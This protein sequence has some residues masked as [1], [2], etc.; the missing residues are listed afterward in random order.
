MVPLC[1]VLVCLFMCAC[2]KKNCASI[3][4]QTLETLQSDSRL[5]KYLCSLC[6]TRID[7][8][9]LVPLAIYSWIG[10]LTTEHVTYLLL[11]LSIIKK[12]GMA[13]QWLK[14]QTVNWLH[15]LLLQ[16]LGNFFHLTLSVS[17]GRDSKSCWPL[18]PGVYARGSKRSHTGGRCVNCCELHLS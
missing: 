7:S 18:L 13:V 16:S 3:S 11:S 10:G 2:A 17:F 1:I 14:H 6:T 5:L 15:V 9:L 4:I 12:W 8:N